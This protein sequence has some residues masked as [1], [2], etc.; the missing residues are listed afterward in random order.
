[1]RWV[2]ILL[3]FLEE[4]SPACGPPSFGFWSCFDVEL[5]Q[6]YVYEAVVVDEAK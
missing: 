6:A 4:G 3:S 5:L 1:V 2:I